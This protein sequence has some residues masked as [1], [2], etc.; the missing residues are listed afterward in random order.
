MKITK[1]TKKEKEFDLN[2][3]LLNYAPKHYGHYKDVVIKTSSF[4]EFKETLSI[5]DE[6]HMRW[7]DGSKLFEDDGEYTY[8]ECDDGCWLTLCYEPYSKKFAIYPRDRY[9]YAN[10]VALIYDS[11]DDFVA[12]VQDLWKRICDEI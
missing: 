5:C 1:K 10:E 12:A 8:F 7:G 9:I 3:F 6:Y 11:L 2:E 4:E